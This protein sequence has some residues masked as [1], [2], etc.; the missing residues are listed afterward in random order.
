M[1]FKYLD[2]AVGLPRLWSHIKAYFQEQ[3]YSFTETLAQGNTVEV[4]LTD[5]DGNPVTDSDGNQLIATLGLGKYLVD[6]EA[7]GTTLTY[8]DHT[9]TA[10]SITTQDTTYSNATTSAA[11]LMSASDKSKLDGITASA[12]AVTY[13]ASLTSGV[14]SGKIGI[15]GTSYSIYSPTNTFTQTQ[16]SGTALGTI[17]L[18]GTSQVIY[19]PTISFSQSLTS[20]TEVGTLNIGSNSYTLYCETNTNTD[21]K[22]QNTLAT[23]TKAYITGTTSAKT[24]TGTQVFDTGVYLDTTA[25]MI[26]ATTFNGDLKGNADTATAADKLN[27]KN[28]GNNGNILIYFADGVPEASIN[29]VGSADK[30]VYVD[31]GVVTTCNDTL[32][33]GITGL[34]YGVSKT[35]NTYDT[36]SDFAD[37]VNPG[38]YFVTSQNEFT[39]TVT[40]MTICNYLVMKASTSSFDTTI[41]GFD[42]S[43]GDVW[44][45]QGSADWTLIANDEQLFA[46][47]KDV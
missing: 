17:S 18:N 31:G 12:D 26:T 30:P 9:G 29:T 16:T 3:F 4:E 6:I 21:T 23:T 41:L 8:T 28:V 20:G 15:N 5:V 45:K 34:A 24:N 19:A 39:T 27:V 14:L 32:S 2:K 7:D 43:N 35:S 46:Y 22:V 25:G 36:V 44:L 1:A 10:T 38:M 11:G 40:D 37:A 33:V 42:V 47:Y 13:T